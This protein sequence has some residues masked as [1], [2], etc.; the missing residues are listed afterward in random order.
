MRTRQTRNSIVQHYNKTQQSCSPKVCCFRF[1]L[2]KTVFMK[3]LT[4]NKTISLFCYYARDSINGLRRD[5]AGRRRPPSGFHP[6]QS[7]YSEDHSEAASVFV[8][9]QEPALGRG[10]KGVRSV[11]SSS[12]APGIAADGSVSTATGHT[13]S[14]CSLRVGTHGSLGLSV[15]LLDLIL[16]FQRAGFN[17]N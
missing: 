4:Y 14:L 9:C 5:S 11:Q 15:G 16:K 17:K 10:R 13:P 3:Y 1:T 6:A 12:W 8:C 7:V 2:S